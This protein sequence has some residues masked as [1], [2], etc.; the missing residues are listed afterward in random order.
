MGYANNPNVI[1]TPEVQQSYR[2]K[3][4]EMLRKENNPIELKQ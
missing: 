3:F 4:A 1:T 2:K